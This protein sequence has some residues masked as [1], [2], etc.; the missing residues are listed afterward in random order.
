[1]VHA[2]IMRTIFIIIDSTIPGD[3]TIGQNRPYHERYICYTIC[4]LPYPG[5]IKPDALDSRDCPSDVHVSVTL[6][7]M[8]NLMALSMT[9]LL[10]Q[11]LYCF[12][13]LF[14]IHFIASN[15]IARLF[16]DISVKPLNSR[17]NSPEKFECRTLLSPS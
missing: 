5:Y 2:M 3:H 13:H 4:I 15:Y 16:S 8:L 1:M 6:I 12:H 14:F 10:S 17:L 9:I 7:F 11:R